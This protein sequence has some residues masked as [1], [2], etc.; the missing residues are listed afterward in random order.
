MSFLKIAD[1]KNVAEVV[2][3]LGQVICV[4]YCVKECVLLNV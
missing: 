1:N 2:V 3:I 4:I